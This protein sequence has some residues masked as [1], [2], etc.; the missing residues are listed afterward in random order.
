MSEFSLYKLSHGIMRKYPEIKGIFCGF[1]HNAVYEETE[2]PIKF[3][4]PGDIRKGR[5]FTVGCHPRG[6]YTFGHVPFDPLPKI[7]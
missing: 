4:N 5:N 7:D 2:L 3:I 6:E 1:T